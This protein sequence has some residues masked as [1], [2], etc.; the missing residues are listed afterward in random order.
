[1]KTLIVD[2]D[3]ATRTALE[4]VLEKWGHDVDSTT[5]GDEAWEVLKDANTPYMIILDWLMPGMDGMTLCRKLREQDDYKPF[6]IIFLTSRGSREDVIEGLEN[7]ADDYIVKPYD[8]GELRARVQ[9]GVR[10]LKLQMELQRR[11]KRQGILEMAG[12]VCHELNQ[13]LQYVSGFSDM[14]LAQGDPEDKNYKM[15]EG[16]KTG[17]DRISKLTKKISLITRY[18]P[19]E[20]MDG[21]DSIVDIKGS[22]GP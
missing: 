1:M 3:P 5:S 4:N 14:L 6:Y 2:D 19:M 20:Y 13:P 16:I 18:Q 7:G 15:I 17:I 21:A 11:E 12:A 8:Y 22:S 10:F 9:V